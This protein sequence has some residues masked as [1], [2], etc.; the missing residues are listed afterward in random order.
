MLFS[1]GPW[2]SEKIAVPI[3][4]SSLFSS[5]RS[6][7]HFK[8]IENFRPQFLSQ[9]HQMAIVAL[10]QGKVHFHHHFGCWATMLYFQGLHETRPGSLNHGVFFRRWKF[11]IQAT[12]FD[13]RFLAFT[14]WFTRYSY[15]ED[16][17]FFLPRLVYTVF[18]SFGLHGVLRV[19]FRPGQFPKV[20]TPPVY[21][22]REL[23]ERSPLYNQ[24]FRV[25]R[26]RN[27]WLYRGLLSLN[28]EPLD[29]TSETSAVVNREG[30]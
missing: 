21:V 14:R 3:I 10:W 12:Y 26:T 4:W 17:T 13:V 23:R 28:E 27:F 30:H 11:G 18:Y 22:V 16:V 1:W 15:S 9:T 25:Q 6:S 7:D 19:I 8:T 5:N 24:K 29:R 2:P 20:I